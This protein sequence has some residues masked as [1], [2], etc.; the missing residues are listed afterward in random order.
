MDTRKMTEIF[1]ELESM[2][3]NKI[4]FYLR[5]GGN[6]TAQL[7]E[8]LESEFTVKEVEHLKN[9]LDGFIEDNESDL[10]EMESEFIVQLR[11]IKSV[12]ACIADCPWRR[13]LCN[14]YSIQYRREW[15][16][17]WQ[18]LRFCVDGEQW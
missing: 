3:G 15:P 6:N 16:G 13:K 14:G 9:L 4:G 10:V 8:I 11:Q 18:C 17:G 5:H 2:A 1:Q 7:N 12:I